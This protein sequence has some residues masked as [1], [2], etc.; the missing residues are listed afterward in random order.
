MLFWR[1]MLTIL[2]HF[3]KFIT[4][5]KCSYEVMMCACEYTVLSEQ[6]ISL[7]EDA[8]QHQLTDYEATLIYFS[9]SM[10]CP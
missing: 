10:L 4:K 1:S 8:E 7:P 9:D 6:Y 2:F 5:Q 3:T